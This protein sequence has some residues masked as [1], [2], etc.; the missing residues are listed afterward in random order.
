MAVRCTRRPR[1]ALAPALAVAAA[2]TLGGAAGAAQDPGAAAPPL[3]LTA[4]NVS[5]SRGPEGDIVLLNGHLHV[6][7]GRTVLTAESGRYQRT[8]GLLDLDGNVR[9]V[10]STTTLTC[11]HASFSE[12]EDLLQVSGHVVINDRDG[13]LRAP[14]GTYDRKTGHVDLVGGVDGKDRNQRLVCDRASYD[15]DSMMVRARGNVHGFDDENKLELQ[16]QAIDFDRR[17]REAVAIGDPVLRSKDDRGRVTEVRAV[18][19]RLNT[20]T[21]VAEAMDSV[22]VERDTLRGRAD[23]ALFDD[24]AGRGWLL[25][26]PRLW[27]GETTVTG[28]TLEFWSEKRVLKRA[29]VRTGATMDYRGARPGTFGETSLLLGRQ[30]EVYFTGDEIDSLVAT[31]T[32]RNDYQDAARPGKTPERNLA[33]G[34]TIT[35]FFKDRKID[36][37]RMH[38]NAAGEYHPPVDEGDTTAVKREV[39]NYDAT[40]IEFEVPRNKIVL[41]EFA[42][43]TYGDLELKAGQVEFDVDRQ[44][45]AA[46]GKPQLYDRGDRV[47]GHLMTYDLTSRVGTIYQAETAYERGLYHGERIRKVGENELDV[48]NGAYSTCDLPEPHYHFSAHYMKIYLK[49]KLVARPVVFYIK[50]V[51]LLA[52]PFYVFPIKPGRHSGFLFPEFEF[53]FSNRSGQFLRNAGY[54]WA[55]NDY[56][57][58]T[59][60]GDYYQAEPSWVL[61][62]ESYYKLQYVL[63]G[64]LRGSFARD[65]RLSRE[66]WDF[67]AAHTQQL[68]ARTRVVA[69][70]SFVSSRDYSAS[71]LFGRSLSQRL[72]RF[73]TS[74]LALSH[75]ADWASFNAVL[76]R[77]QDLDADLGIQDPDG[78]GPLQGPVPGTVASLANL[79]ETR[80]NLSVSFPTRIIGTFGLLKGTPLEKPLRSLYFGLD[81]RF[82]SQHERRAFVSGYRSFLRDTVLDSTTVLDQRVTTRRALAANTSLSDS[83]RLF[84]WLTFSPRVAANSVVWDFDEQGHEVVPSATWASSATMGSTFY[85]SFRPHWGP[86]VGLRHVIFPSVSFSYS[87]EFRGL[88]FTDSLGVQRN[89]FTAFDGIGISGFKHASLS[90]AL[91]QRLQAKVKQ[92]DAVQRLDNLL[93]WS[94]SGSYD[95]LYREHRLA[96]P[97]STLGSSLFLQPPGLL[98]ASLSWS[99][100]VYSPRPMRSLSGNTGF[101]L[102]SGGGRRAAAPPLPV[103]QTQPVAE[104]EPRFRDTWSLGLAYSYAG[105]Y[106]GPSWS[107]RQTAN[108][109]LHYQL[110]PG[111]TLDYATSYDITFHNLL[112][113]RFSLQRDIHCW[114]ASFTRTFAPGGEA[115]YYFRLGIKDQREIY[116]ERGT[117]VG[118]IGGIQ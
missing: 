111:W 72:N 66:D 77:R 107:S 60:A 116:I 68:S 106:E 9:M 38:G 65:D 21:R 44:T 5:G 45:L 41:D 32:A 14:S 98:S 47:T 95:F 62:A 28:D 22:T 13:V 25:G 53:G 83:R 75:L 81:T 80:P 30:V 91:D 85:G 109:V 23:Y 31:G 105:G 11:D 100:D 110:S 40:R 18:H 50:N 84:G 3:N 71:N 74:S 4:D 103:E 54:Y 88:T 51:P 15:R 48:L 114:Q 6:T 10:D 92:R 42:H 78:Q 43:L 63:D 59:L 17:T 67:N 46:K 118:S 57:D 7:R 34:D 96:H 35:V 12:D 58:L 76:D 26:R 86:V 79:V 64:N 113:Q 101:T 115:E 52:L 70:G 33:H 49:D 56:F 87:P 55:P 117:R 104:A 20:D 73:L 61:R 19:L 99:T 29:V 82:V 24:Q 112:T 90:F 102:A 37:A 39:V 36:R 108:A 1:G 8:H 69:V 97:L 93:S 27:D 2:L 16:A 89:R 94:V